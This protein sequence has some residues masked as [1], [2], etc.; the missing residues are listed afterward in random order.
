MNV[1]NIFVILLSVL[2]NQTIDTAKWIIIYRHNP[3]PL[4]ALLDQKNTICC[5][6]QI[7]NTLVFD[8][9]GTN[10]DL[11]SGDDNK[12][13]TIALDQ[14]LNIEDCHLYIELPKTASKSEIKNTIQAFIN[15]YQTQKRMI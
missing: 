8:D 5:I 11:L 1:K 9:D 4:L 12:L 2:N 6:E 10:F 15:A 3:L 13:K 7:D 14:D